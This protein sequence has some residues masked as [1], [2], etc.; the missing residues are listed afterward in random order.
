MIPYELAHQLKQAGFPK[1]WILEYDGTLRDCTANTR[2]SLSE[3]IE[4]CLKMSIKG[5]ELDSWDGSGWMASGRF[6]GKT[7]VS[8]TQPT[9]EIAIAHLFLALIK[10][11]TDTA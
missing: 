5:F 9:P 3:L 2:I 8:G 4:A 11:G 6:Y 1:D 10:Y 7:E